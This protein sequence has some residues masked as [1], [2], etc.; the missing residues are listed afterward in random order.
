MPPRRLLIADDDEDDRLFFCEA[1]KEIEPGTECI[2]AI[3]GEDVLEKL[4][5]GLQQLPNYIFLDLNMPPM[6]GF[7]CFEELKQD[8]KLK[9][10]PVVIFSTTSSQR[11]IDKMLAL[12][13]LHFIVKPTSLKKLSDELLMCSIS[14]TILK[15]ILPH[16]DLKC[17]LCKFLQELYE[18]IFQKKIIFER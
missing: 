13:A 18:L 7:R 17:E 16:Q 4:R 15:E 3:N 11:E 5:S 8:D 12:G 1:V 2:T 14:N 10:I 9:N 6:N